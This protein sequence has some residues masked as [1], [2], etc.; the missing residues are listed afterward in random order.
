MARYGTPSVIRFFWEG[1]E[2]V[3][4]LDHPSRLGAMM[5]P[6]RWTSGCS[7]RPAGHHCP[8]AGGERWNTE[9]KIAVNW[10]ARVVYED[11]STA[12]S[13]ISPSASLWWRGVAPLD[14]WSS[15][16]SIH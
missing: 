15:G 9:V 6:P 14:S 13:L 4:L 11:M 8:D 5:R 12:A 16:S 10:G 2:H 3:Q 1:G 7:W